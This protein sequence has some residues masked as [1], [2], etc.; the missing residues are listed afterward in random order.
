MKWT[1]FEKDIIYQKLTQEEKSYLIRLAYIKE[2]ESI[3][4]KFPKQ[5]AAGLDRFTHD[6]MKHLGMKLPI[7]CN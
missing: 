3:I 1:N 6:S 4:N 2:I 7:L 5:K